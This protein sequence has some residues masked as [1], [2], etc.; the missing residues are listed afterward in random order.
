[1]AEAAQARG[2]LARMA[3]RPLSR[4]RS[5]ELETSGGSRPGREWPLQESVPTLESCQESVATLEPLSE[6]VATLVHRERE[7]SWRP[8]LR[9][10]DS[11]HGR[12]QAA[13]GDESSHHRGFMQPSSSRGKS[14]REAFAGMPWTLGTRELSRRA[15]R[16]HLR[17][18]CESPRGWT[19]TWKA[20]APKPSSAPNISAKVRAESTR[21]AGPG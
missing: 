4:S 7:G 12:T 19:R 2:R 5:R 9:S 10:R 1:M 16:K 11:D 20:A 6:G 18:A 15:P 21:M 8:A 14:R 13:I 17:P 3:S